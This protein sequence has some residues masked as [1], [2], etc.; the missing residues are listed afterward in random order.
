MN[1]RRIA[2]NKRYEYIPASKPI[3]VSEGSYRVGVIKDR[4]ENRIVL[5][6]EIRKNFLQ[7]NHFTMAYLEEVVCE[8]DNN[9]CAL[10][11]MDPAF[12]EFEFIRT[13]IGVVGLMHELGHYLYHHFDKERTDYSKLRKEA[14]ESGGVIDEELQADRFAVENCGIGSF[15]KFIN[16]MESYAPY[17]RSEEN[18]RQAIKEFEMRKERAINAGVLKK[19]R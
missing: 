14:I 15:I 12:Y 2:I 10:V 8:K 19:V 13:K 4:I 5:I 7:D 1:K 16:F 3:K 9:K 11:V 6:L 17:I 18:C